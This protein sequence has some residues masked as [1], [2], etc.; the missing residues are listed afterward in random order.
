MAWLLQAWLDQL[1]QLLPCLS[2]GKHHHA[3]M[4]VRYAAD[5]IWLVQQCAD[6]GQGG[7]ATQQVILASPPD[8][9]PIQVAYNQATVSGY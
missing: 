1:E 5:E 7:P 6:H 3:E 4:A 2:L 8:G 9:D